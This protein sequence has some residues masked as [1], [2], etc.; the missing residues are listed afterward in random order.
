MR[1]KLPLWYNEGFNPKP[2]M[3]FAAPLSIGTESYA[4]FV[5]IRLSERISPEEALVSL[6]R[7]MTSEL[8]AIEAYYPER[9]LTELKWLSYTVTLKTEGSSQKLAAECESALLSDKVEIEKK[10]KS[11]ELA[12]VDIR[13]LIKS[14]NAT[15][16]QGEI[17]ISAVLS[18]D[19]SAFLNPEHLIKYLKKR[20]NVLTSPNLLS[21]SYSI[22]RNEAYLDDMSVFR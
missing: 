17:K 12:T 5:D 18:A 16:D 2:K 3:V 1:A 22:I 4:E 9:K 13:P 11:G 19:P 10:T 7:N 14:I 8:Q 20:L 6:N 15:F 21:E